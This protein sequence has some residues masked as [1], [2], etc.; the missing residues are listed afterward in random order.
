MAA[1]GD[2]KFSK[3]AYVEIHK[4]KAVVILIGMFVVAVSGL[5]ARVS[6]TTILVRST[7]VFL[8]VFVVSRIVI[9]ILKTNEEMNSG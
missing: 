3:A 9:Q 7:V 6:L 1:K 8:A 5:M 4:L 2:K